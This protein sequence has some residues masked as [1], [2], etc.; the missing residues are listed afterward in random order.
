MSAIKMISEGLKKGFIEYGGRC[1]DQEDFEDILAQ[2][3]KDELSQE[4]YL[5]ERYNSILVDCFLRKF[6]KE[7]DYNK[8]IDNAYLHNNRGMRSDEEISYQTKRTRMTARARDAIDNI[9]KKA[10]DYDRPKQIRKSSRFIEDGILAIAPFQIEE[11]EVAAV[12]I[13]IEVAV[14]A[15]DNNDVVDAVPNNDDIVNIK[16]DGIASCIENE[17]VIKFNE[18]FNIN[19]K[20]CICF[21]EGEKITMGKL[22]CECK[23]V[24]HNICVEELL[25][26]H[27]KCPFCR[28][29]VTYYI[30]SDGNYI[31]PEARMEDGEYV[32]DVALTREQSRA[33]NAIK[34]MKERQEQEDELLNSDTLFNNE[35]AKQNR[36]ENINKLDKE[37]NERRERQEI[38]RNQCISSSSSTSSSNGNHD[39]QNYS[40]DRLNIDMD[41]EEENPP[42][43]HELARESGTA[44]SISD[45]ELNKLIDNFVKSLNL[46]NLANNFEASTDCVSK[47]IGRISELGKES[48]NADIADAYERKCSD[49]CEDEKEPTEDEIRQEFCKRGREN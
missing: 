2:K 31:E 29:E 40:I 25:H 47:V 9:A 42:D 23:Y 36:N 33:R 28:V 20:C 3:L 44:H 17:N 49:A 38:R 34:R 48:M 18:A 11:M 1:K 13:M 43:Q 45:I 46:E 39:Q 37:R 32:E 5:E 15:E 4:E 41:I 35:R 27:H 7:C 6:L 24:M 10:Y 8:Y 22:P 30:D 12:D 26:R 16:I 21:E 19:E 14:D